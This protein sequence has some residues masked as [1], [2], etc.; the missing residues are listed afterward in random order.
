MSKGETVTSLLSC[1]IFDSYFYKKSNIFCYTD[2]YSNAIIFFYSLK[3]KTTGC[4]IN[5]PF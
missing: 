5:K 2:L 1:M 3:I 4:C